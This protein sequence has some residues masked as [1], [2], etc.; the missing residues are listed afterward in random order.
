[1]GV[2]IM[3]IDN[4]EP[5]RIYKDFWD[6]LLIDWHIIFIAALVIGYPYYLT[7]TEEV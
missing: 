3:R 6:W 4:N 7:T 5:H 1:M 2:S